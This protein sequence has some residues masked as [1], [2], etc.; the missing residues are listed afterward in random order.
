MNSHILILSLL[1]SF[2]VNASDSWE[3][4]EKH[5]PSGQFDFNVYAVTWQPTYCLKDSADHCVNQ[6]YVHGVWP[7]FNLPHKEAANTHRRN[8]LNYH[9]SYCY[10][11]PGCLSGKDC[12]INDQQVHSIM[13]HPSIKDLYPKSAS[14]FKHEW[15][16]HG[17]CSGMN[18][19]DYFLQANTYRKVIFPSLEPLYKFINQ[20]QTSFQISVSYIKS[21]LPENTGLRCMQV[22]DRAMLFEI[23]FFIDPSGKP[24]TT[25]TQIGIPCSGQIVIPVGHES[26]TDRF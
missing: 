26:G 3:N 6:F 19:K 24:H 7:Y 8:V 15:H 4:E 25:Q 21:L 11:S 18:P 2:S 9:P 20:H 12:E 1:F 14:L 23:F 5:A 17:T 13:N 10:N 16:K 22:N